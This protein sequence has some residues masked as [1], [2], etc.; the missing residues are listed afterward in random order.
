LYLAILL[1]LQTLGGGVRLQE[2]VPKID[3]LKDDC[4]NFLTRICS[5]PAVG[6]ES[7]GTGEMEKY[8][9]IRDEV[10]SL[11]P[12]MVEEIHAPDNR[13]PD[14]IR[15]NLVAV[16]NGK[17]TSK[18]L[19]IL[20]HIDVVP[21]GELSLWDHDPFQPRV[22]NG[23]ITGR[24]V[25]DNGQALAASIFA[26]KSVAATT[27][28]SMNVGLAL[29]SDE[30]SGSLYGLDYVLKKRAELFRPEDLIIVPDAGNKD[31]DQIEVAEKHLF[32][33]RFKVSGKQGHA[34]RPDQSTNTLRAASHFIVELDQ[35]LSA[36]FTQKNSFFNPPTS[37]FE[38]TKK[39]ANV[40]NINTIP[41]EDVFYFDCRVLPEI[42]LDSVMGEMQNVAKRIEDRFGVK[43]TVEEFLKNPSAEPTP[44]DS[45]VVVALAQAIQEVYGVQARPNGIGGQTVALFFRRKGLPA[46]VWEKI[47]GTAHAPNEKISVENLMGN[48]KVFSRMM[49]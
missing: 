20:S 32:H 47:F 4:V 42:N 6:P 27:G 19:W 10:L 30:E 2:I 15:P 17:N 24:G 40:P 22:Q 49:I 28:F 12:D 46:A 29:V 23:I 38:P 18:T 14:G 35:S 36:R 37:T 43:T 5:I 33:V 21:P 13:V 3:E 44:S 1:F 25:E 8:R 9:V 48:I 16:F 41:G 39:E 7:H 11:K 31:G 26:V 45:P 34:S